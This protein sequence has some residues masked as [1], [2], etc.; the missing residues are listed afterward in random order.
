MLL[1]SSCKA[2]YEALLVKYNTTQEKKRNAIKD[3]KVCEKKIA[4]DKEKL[5]QLKPEL[6]FWKRYAAESTQIVNYK[7]RFINNGYKAL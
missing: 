6:E 7:K 3:T 1:L 4:A 2:K 5:K